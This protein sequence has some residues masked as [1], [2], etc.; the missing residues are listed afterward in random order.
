LCETEIEDDGS[1]PLNMI[2]EDC[3]DGVRLEL[4]L[5]LRLRL[6]I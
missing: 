4:N 6:K 1:F 2:C 5:G 3:E